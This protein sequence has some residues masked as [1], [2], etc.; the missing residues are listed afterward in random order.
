MLDELKTDDE[1]LLEKI[2]EVD[3]ERDDD[4]LLVETML[5]DLDEEDDEVNTTLDDKLVGKRE[6]TLETS[7]ILFATEDDETAAT[8]GGDHLLIS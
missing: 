1:L 7:W 3:N 6:G 8:A 5:E 4:E 2:L